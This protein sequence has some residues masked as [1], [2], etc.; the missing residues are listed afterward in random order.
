MKIHP[1]PLCPRFSTVSQESCH[2]CVA[3]HVNVG[4]WRGCFQNIGYQFF[5]FTVLPWY[6]FWKC[7]N[8]EKVEPQ[9]HP[10]AYFWH[11]NKW[12]LFFV[13]LNGILRKPSS[14][15]LL[16][17]C[18]A[19]ALGMILKN[20]KA[21]QLH[22]GE[23]SQVCMG[24]PLAFIGKI[25][26]R[27]L[28]FLFLSSFCPRNFVYFQSMMDRNLKVMPPRNQGHCG[29][30]CATTS[31]RTKSRWG[32]PA[33]KREIDFV[34]CFNPS[35]QLARNMKRK[36]EEWKD[37]FGFEKDSFTFILDRVVFSSNS[38][39]RSKKRHQIRNQRTA[40]RKQ[41]VVMEPYS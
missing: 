22:G 37:E 3:Q 9:K 12:I 10:T 5:G 29:S 17:K 15:W 35:V 28:F 40:N 20:T 25:E 14:S 41:E 7:I 21:R 6:F 24:L 4:P 27:W 18:I 30:D 13:G 23:V 31:E 34:F 11:I 16:R 8:F 33:R 1:N 39:V 19:W 38:I 26:T 2:H 32:V 36:M